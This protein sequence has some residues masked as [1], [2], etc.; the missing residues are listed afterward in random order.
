MLAWRQ[1]P[2]GR[3]HPDRANDTASILRSINEDIRSTDIRHE[4]A[5]RTF[6]PVDSVHKWRIHRSVK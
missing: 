4:R 5:A 2:L 3:K 6:V 1:P